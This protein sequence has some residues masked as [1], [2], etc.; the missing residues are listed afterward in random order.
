MGI[1]H[2]QVLIRCLPLLFS[3]VFSPF[4]LFLL[5]GSFLLFRRVFL[6][7]WWCLAFEMGCLAALLVQWQLLSVWFKTR[8]VSLRVSSI[9]ISARNKCF[10]LLS[11]S[12]F[13]RSFRSSE[14]LLP[15]L[16]C[17]DAPVDGDPKCQLVPNCFK[18][19]DICLDLSLKNVDFVEELFFVHSSHRIL[20]IGKQK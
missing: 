13:S 2:S 8:P 9:G 3:F 14:S 20:D 7:F 4:W 19:S 1:G 16:A 15:S 5:W 10:C 11:F 18:L 17:L 6:T 12:L